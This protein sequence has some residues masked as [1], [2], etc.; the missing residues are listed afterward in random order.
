MYSTSV[1][2][3]KGL[4][5]HGLFS[6]YMNSM[7]ACNSVTFYFMKNSFSDVSR[8][9]ILP[10]MIR[11]EHQKISFS[12][13]KRNGITSLHG[14]HGLLCLE[15]SFHPAIALKSF[16]QNHDFYYAV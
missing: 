6:L 11:A 9:W 14:I 10:N 16:T 15:T 8:K 7:Q 2:Y 1:I 5:K 13:I 12:E 4:S 3:S